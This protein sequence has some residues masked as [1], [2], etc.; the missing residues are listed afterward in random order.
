[1]KTKIIILSIAAFMTAGTVSQAQHELGFH[2]YEQKR[3]A[4]VQEKQDPGSFLNL[5][6][7][8]QNQMKRLRL[9]H[10]KE[11]KPLINQLRENRAHYKTLL[12]ADQ[13]DIKE[14]NKSIDEFTAI[15]NEM[16]KSGVSFKL[17]MRNI[18]TD[19]QKQILEDHRFQYRR[20][21]IHKYGFSGPNRNMR[22]RSGQMEKGFCPVRGV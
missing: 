10:Q 12:S 5:T 18:L 21:Q 9:E 2:G 13:P 8:Q 6:E 22:G 20:G 14:I 1:M 4:Q 7:D 11:V 3:L 19:D 17:E 16:Q 15:R